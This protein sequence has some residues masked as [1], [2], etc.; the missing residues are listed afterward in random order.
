MLSTCWVACLFF[1][2]SESVVGSIGD[3]SASSNNVGGFKQFRARLHALE[4]ERHFALVDGLR[5][6][7]PRLALES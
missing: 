7:E 1:Q 5:L 4:Q 6:S 3:K 2:G